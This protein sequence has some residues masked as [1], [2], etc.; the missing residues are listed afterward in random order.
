MVAQFGLRLAASL[1]KSHFGDVVGNVCDCLLRRGSLSLDDL[2]KFTKMPTSQVKEC[3]LVLIQHNC[4]QAFSIPGN[5]GGHLGTVTQ[6]MALFDNILHQL[7]FPKFSVI[8]ENHLGEQG[9]RE[10]GIKKLYGRISIN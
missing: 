1:I 9:V 2:R 3:V 6:Y 10:L 4:V 5:F 8:V 7:R